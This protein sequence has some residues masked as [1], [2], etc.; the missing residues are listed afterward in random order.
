MKI[1][2]TGYELDKE[3]RKTV[4]ELLAEAQARLRRLEPREALAASRSGR[5]LVD[6]RGAEQVAEQGTIPGAIWIP[7]N[8]L[9][10]RVDPA[11]GD[12]H[13]S[14]AGRENDVVLICAE[15]YQS[16]LAAATLHDL[17]FTGVT[18]VVGGFAAWAAAG[19]PVQREL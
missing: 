5:V 4:D 2:L 19:L 3:A 6:I 7:R 8:V 11:S 15:G 14:L 17:G 13:P 10:W 16:S 9:E 12:Q 1:A 18:D